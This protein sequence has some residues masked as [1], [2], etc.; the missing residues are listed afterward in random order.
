MWKDSVSSVVPVS[1]LVN[2]GLY[3]SICFVI[4]RGFEA[5]E[6]YVAPVRAVYGGDPSPTIEPSLSN[7]NLASIFSSVS[8]DVDRH[9]GG[10]SDFKISPVCFP[11]LLWKVFNTFVSLSQW[12]ICY[13]L[14]GV[15][16]TRES[17]SHRVLRFPSHA[18]V[19]GGGNGGQEIF[20]PACSSLFKSE[21]CVDSVISK[22]VEFF[23]R[24]ILI[25]SVLAAVFFAEQSGDPEKIS[26]SHAALKSAMR[27][28]SDRVYDEGAVFDRLLKVARNLGARNFKALQALANLKDSN[29]VMDKKLFAGI[30]GRLSILFVGKVC[31][32]WNSGG[33]YEIGLSDNWQESLFPKESLPLVDQESQE[34]CELYILKEILNGVVNSHMQAGEVYANSLVP[35]DENLNLTGGGYEAQSKKSQFIIDFLRVFGFSLR[36]LWRFFLQESRGSITK[37]SLLRTLLEGSTAVC[38]KEDKKNLHG[39]WTTEVFRK[40]HSLPLDEVADLIQVSLKGDEQILEAAMAGEDFA[41]SLILPVLKKSYEKDCK[42]RSKKARQD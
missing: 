31:G 18:E 34:G 25:F 32:D 30:Y 35:M 17:A 22:S 27:N 36:P 12:G 2:L 23:R 41:K 19:A 28:I 37:A 38:P 10:E 20:L 15:L 16:N 1:S 24:T 14:V 5:G 39:G 8:T 26:Q 29:I 9:W 4:I 42:L 21:M 33:G 7:S 6:I 40:K 13:P 3:C 11:S